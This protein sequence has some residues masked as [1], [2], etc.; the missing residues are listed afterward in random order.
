MPS[1]YY[2]FKNDVQ[3][4]KRPFLFKW[5]SKFPWLVYSRVLKGVLCV[6]C[7]LFRAH[8]KHG[9]Y[10]GS[11]ITNA[12]MHFHKFLEKAKQH[13]KNDWHIESCI[14]SKDFMDMMERNSGVDQILDSHYKN[15]ITENRNKLKPIVT[16][17]LFCAL[18]NLPIRGDNDSTAV[19]NN[20]LEFR[21]NAGDLVLKSHLEKSS[22]N[23]L[24]ISHRV[25]NE[26]IE[27]ASSTLRSVIT[28]EVRQAFCFSI[29][30][31]ETADISGVE[32]L[33]ICVRY[34]KDKLVHEEFLGFFPLL[35]FDA[36][37]IT[38]TI[39][40]ACSNI[41]IDMNKCVGQGYDGCATMAGHISGVQKRIND[42]YPMAHFF[43]CASH[44]LNLVINDL[45]SVT[46]VR[47][48]IG[49]IKETIIFFRD[50]AVR[51]NIIG[52]SGLTKLC[53]TRF[54]EK[55]KSVRQFYERFVTIVEGLEEIS[56][57]NHL[58]CKTKQR[59][60]ELL[61][62]ITTPTFVVI[63]S[64][65]SKYSAKFEII[66]TVLQG[67]DVDLQR[68]T[69]HIQDL[70]TMLQK[71]RDDC[72]TQFSAIFERAIDI[73]SK[74]DLE[75][76]LPRRNARQTHRENYPTNN[77]QDY[78]RQSLFIPYIDSIIMSIKD[79]FSDE[80]LKIFALFDLHPKKMKLMDRQAFMK[81]LKV[82]SEMYGSLLD[83]FEEQAL[84]WYELW[85]DKPLENDMKLIDIL[86]YETFY[87]AVCMAIQIFITLPATS[88]SVERSFR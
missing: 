59:S 51:K 47:N 73:A 80:K 21:I 37:F 46:E 20:L 54:V 87:P 13:E 18:H 7:V 10:Q 44:R 22:K 79:R 70:L 58:N 32:Q 57:S 40:E 2:N 81:T 76:T 9:S 77:I 68:A 49:K 38:K 52:G 12:F 75:L 4:G 43:H 69:R 23:A 66:S 36:K 31:D 83:N 60:Y 3:I 6:H 39:L 85:Q 50:N 71:D 45:N 62:A 48:C 19:F 26:L 14:R 53:E 42:V 11:F 61:A 33:S 55:H 34:L 5:F 29:I 56:K 67:I 72:E 8:V 25:Q 64:I 88:C 41:D 63:L 27:C 82:I 24:Y 28:N 84:S 17:L 78:Y 15:K 30:A 1:K 74:I 35:E 65:I 86:D 16:S